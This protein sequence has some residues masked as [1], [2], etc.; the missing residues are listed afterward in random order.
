MAI[1]ESCSMYHDGNLLSS[2]DSWFEKHKEKYSEF[3]IG[4]E[5]F[6]SFRFKKGLNKGDI[7]FVIGT[8][9]AKVEISDVI[10]FN[11][12]QKNPIIMILIFMNLK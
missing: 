8:D 2:S 7:L 11:A 4:K 6:G 1:V 12:N 10:I 3:K 5:G 9:P